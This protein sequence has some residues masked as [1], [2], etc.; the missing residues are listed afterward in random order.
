VPVV[1]LGNTA[2]RHGA[3]DNYED[4]P[5]N[6]VTTVHIPDSYTRQEA[7]RTIWHDDGLWT[8]HS[9]QPPAWVECGEEP[10]LASA[11][12]AVYD[13]PIGRPEDWAESAAELSDPD[14]I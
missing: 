13:C 9:S 4:L 5:G 8:R 12:S 3:T 1:R 2:A 7:L 11:L 14:A 6:R 10:G